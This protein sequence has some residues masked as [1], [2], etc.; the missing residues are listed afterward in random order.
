MDGRP[1]GPLERVLSLFADVRGGEGRGVVLLACN[2]FLLLAAYYLL[3]VAREQLILTQ[4]GA[5]VAAYS[6][7]AQAVLLIGFVP[8]Y[9]WL[10]SR[11]VRL[12][13]I[14]VSSLFFAMNLGLFYLAGRSGLQIGV[15]FFIWLGIFNIFIVSQF[16]AFANDIYTE[17]Q[18]KRL[19]PIV[20]VGASLGAWI[21]AAA[22]PG[23]V[24]DYQFTPYTLMLLGAVLLILA[25]GLTI[26]V[27]RREAAR[28]DRDASVAAAAT[29]PLGPAGGFRL[30]ARERYLLWIAVLI[31]LLNVVNTT[32]EFL[33]RSVVSAEA[34][35][36]VGSDTALQEAFIG[37]FYGSFFGAVNLLGFLIQLFLTSRLIRFFGVRG[38]LFILPI[39]AFVNYSVIAFAPLLAVV[40]IGK[41]LENSTDYS[42]QNTV[43]QALFLPTSRE[44]K[45]KAKVAIDTFGTRLGDVMS[46]GFVAAGT[47]LGL[48]IPGFGLLNVGLTTLWLVVAGRIAKEHKRRVPN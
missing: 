41:I 29:Q 44:A 10:G 23:L 48:G 7:A 5:T 17:G 27:N 6:S 40:R 26:V 39:V 47:A 14:S 36:Q 15:V 1:K 34:L 13:L 33:L 24:A 2:I 21:G 4:G 19:F 42:L 18:G 9:G 38:A 25:L 28:T 11:L 8:L 20:G 35:V 30:I 12:R 37:R 16:W 22:V 46:A 43:R 3:K 31:V 45:Y 32:G